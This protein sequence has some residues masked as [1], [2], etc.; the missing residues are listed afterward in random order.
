MSIDSQFFKVRAIQFQTSKNVQIPHFAKII[1]ILPYFAYPKPLLSL[2]LS[3]CPQKKEKKKKIP[4]VDIG[5]RSFYY[6]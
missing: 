6:Y 3:T 4:I 5:I 1:N 2:S